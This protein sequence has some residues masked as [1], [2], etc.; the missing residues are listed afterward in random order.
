METAVQLF[1]LTFAML[2]MIMVWCT[3]ETGPK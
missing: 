2:L 1:K 3:S